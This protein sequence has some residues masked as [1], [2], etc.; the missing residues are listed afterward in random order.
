MKA[1]LPK[2]LLT[3]LIAPA[4]LFAF[5]FKADRT[6][7]SGTWKLNESKS[8]LGNFGRFAPR[9]IKA[10]QKDD[11][12]AISRTAPSF[13]GNDVTT[14]ETLSYDG[15]ET[16]TTVFGNSKRKSTAKWSDDGKTFT[17]NYTLLLDF[18]GQTNEIKGTE[19]WALSDDGKALTV[20]THST[21]SQGERSTKYV[22][23]KE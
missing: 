13:D 3:L 22:Y 11:A 8:E 7:F 4:F 10:D 5:T 2:K 18:N 17:I 16:E 6:N 19:T 14:T 23:D 12:L 1:A 21:S 9:T 20:Q 15:K